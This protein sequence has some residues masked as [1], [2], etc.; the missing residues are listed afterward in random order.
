MVKV[1]DERDGFPNRIAQI[2][3]LVEENAKHL[4]VQNPLY[5]E[6]AEETEADLLCNEDVL[7]DLMDRFNGICPPDTA[8]VDV[9]SFPKRF[10]CFFVKKLIQRAEIPNVLVTYTQ[11]RPHGYPEDPLAEEFQQPSCLPGFAKDTTGEHC[12]AASLGFESY[13]LE[14]L[15]RQFGQKSNTYVLTSFPP[16]GAYTRRQWKVI[17]DVLKQC[18]DYRKLEAVSALDIE[19][20]HSVLRGWA[21]NA[22][23]EVILAPYGP[24]PHSVAM[25]LL[26]ME[27][28][29]PIVYTQPKSYNPQYCSGI[30][31]SW[32]YVLKW[33]GVACYE[34]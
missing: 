10:F 31:Q 15:I 32:A 29:Y 1:N 17:K 18:F 27:R 11:P 23:S 12:I 16:D 3:R 25:V 13:H 8:V 14:G 28:G 6:S 33:D 4:R 7:L 21:E 9:S 22:K 20:A 19:N 2:T 24:K 5:A 30:G 26:A 34:R